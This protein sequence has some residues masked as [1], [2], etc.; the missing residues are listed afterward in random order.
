MKVLVTDGSGYIGQAATAAL[1]DGADAGPYAHTGGSWVYGNT[2]G[3]VTEDAPL[4]PPSLVPGGS[5]T[6]SRCSPARPVADGRS[7]RR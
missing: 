4:A 2:C 6:R 1:Q 3:L 5:A 7:W